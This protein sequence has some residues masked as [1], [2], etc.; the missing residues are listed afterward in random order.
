M[1]NFPTLADSNGYALRDFSTKAGRGGIT[2][3]ICYQISGPIWLM[4][5][6]STE[7]G[8]LLWFLQHPLR[9]QSSSLFK[10]TIV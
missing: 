5:K 10:Q 4:K 3:D 6:W 7:T 1:G 9:Y 8:L 2:C